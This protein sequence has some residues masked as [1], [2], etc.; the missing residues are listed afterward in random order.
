[1]NVNWRKQ[2]AADRTVVGRAPGPERT[3]MVPRAGQSERVPQVIEG[4]GDGGEFFPVFPAPAR[5]V[6]RETPIRSP[7]VCSASSLP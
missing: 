5:H 6:G 2:E 7:Y 3:A 4:K 1:M